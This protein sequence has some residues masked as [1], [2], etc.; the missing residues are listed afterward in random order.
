MTA[1]AILAAKIVVACGIYGLC[2]VA[3]FVLNR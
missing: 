1:A 3:L 2:D